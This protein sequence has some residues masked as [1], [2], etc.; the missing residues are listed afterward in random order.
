[1]NWL[2]GASLLLLLSYIAYLKIGILKRKDLR[3]LAYAVAPRRA[4]DEIY[5]HLRPI[6]D[7]LID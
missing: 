6:I 7:K 5:Q 2:V 4:V 1:M 3:E